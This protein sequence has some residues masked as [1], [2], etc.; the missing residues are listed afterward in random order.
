MTKNGL[1]SETACRMCLVSRHT[2]LFL[3][4]MAREVRGAFSLFREGIAA[5]AAV[6]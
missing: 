2:D 6:T 1:L 4:C 5:H 3:T